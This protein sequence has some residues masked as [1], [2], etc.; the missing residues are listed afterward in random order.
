MS[1]VSIK[2]F[3]K[4]LMVLYSTAFSMILAL[5]FAVAY[6]DPSKCVVVDIN[7]VGEANI[8]LVLLTILIPLILI[9]NLS[10]AID[11]IGAK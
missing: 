9:C 6:L 11:M 5:I 8:E 1:K 10:V 7:S 2:Q 4:T 3:T